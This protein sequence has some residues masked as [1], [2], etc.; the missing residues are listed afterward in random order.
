MTEDDV[1]TFIAN[2][3]TNLMT[4]PGKINLTLY[5]KQPTTDGVQLLNVTATVDHPDLNISVAVTFS[6]P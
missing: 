5:D 3:L 6:L 2:K 4:D 1:K